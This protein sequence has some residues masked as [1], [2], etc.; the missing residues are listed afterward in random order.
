MDNTNIFYHSPK[1]LTTDAFWVWLLYFLDSDA[2]YEFAKQTLFDRLILK[3][4]D[5]GRRVGR[6]SVVRQKKGAHGR[7]DFF[8]TFSFLDDDTKNHVL[9]E[10][11]TWTTTSAEQL[12]GYK[13]DYPD[14]YRY[15]YYKLAYISLSERA[16]VEGNGYDI[17]TSRMM[18]SCLSLFCDAHILIKYYRDY[19]ND[20]FADYIDSFHD[21]LFNNNNYDLLWDAQ[22]QLFLADKLWEVMPKDRISEMYIY[23]GTSSGRPW[24]EISISDGKTIIPGYDESLF[25]RIDIRKGQFYI[26]LNQYSWYEDDEQ[27]TIYLKKQE[28]L[29]KLR[30][31]SD[32]MLENGDFSLIKGKPTDVGS[33]EQEIVIFFL[34]DNAWDTIFEEIP[35]FTDGYLERYERLL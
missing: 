11:K 25:W 7:V 3:S 24:T 29:R 23:N 12:N 8:F 21:Q 10:D 16:L 30:C 20:K 2:E 18:E 1:E 35:R 22:A 19:V 27:R 33:Y 28:R 15:F 6:I 13:E 31:I 32:D 26:R 34:H 14:A 9:F 4:Q 17:I 5:C